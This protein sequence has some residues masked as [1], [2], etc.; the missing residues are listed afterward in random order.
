MHVSARTCTRVLQQIQHLPWLAVQEVVV[1]FRRARACVPVHTSVLQ[2]I[3][4]TVTGSSRVKLSSGVFP[5]TWVRARAQVCYSKSTTYPDWQFTKFWCTT[6]HVRT[7]A[8]TNPTPTSCRQHWPQQGT[9][10]FHF[11]C[12]L[13]K[14]SS[15]V[16]PCRAR[17]HVRTCTTVTNPTPTMTGISRV[18]LSS[19]VF[20]CTWV[21]FRAHVCYNK[22][23]TYP[24]WQFTS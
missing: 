23:N 3:V 17:A 11:I 12:R 16:L 7:C 21:C 5:C 10:L 20:S 13:F 6:V 18:K 1:S 4:T 8:T 14:Q 19:G 22:S 9:V 15:G 2:Q 24:D